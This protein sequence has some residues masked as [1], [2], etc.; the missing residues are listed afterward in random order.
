MLSGRL[1]TGTRTLF[2]VRGELWPKEWVN[3]GR[4]TPR[5]RGDPMPPYAFHITDG[6]GT[7]ECQETLR[8]SGKRLWF[9]PGVIIALADRRG[10]GIDWYTP[11]RAHFS[12]NRLGLVN[13]MAKERAF[14]SDW[15]QRIWEGFNVTPEG[16]VSEELYGAQA[17]GTAADTQTPEPFLA[18]GIDR[19]NR[20]ATVKLGCRLFREHQQSRTL[21]AHT[22]RFR[23]VD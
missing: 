19:L 1:Q 7:R 9:G 22:H 6:A 2:T 11:C 15:Q 23:A 13:V 16:K 4:C 10:G 12:V 8:D 14:L 17:A 21:L 20:V 18:T 3:P 5:L